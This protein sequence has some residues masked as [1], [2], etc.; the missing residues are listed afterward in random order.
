MS[1]LAEVVKEETTVEELLNPVASAEAAGLRYVSDEM[2]GIRRRKRGDSFS[3]VDPDGETVEHEKT[4]ARIESLVIPPAWTEVWI[5]PRANGHLQATGRD[6]KGRKQYRYHSKWREV[7]DAVKYD[8]MLDF[9][10]A[11]P[12][13]RRRVDRD[14]SLPGLPREKVLATVVRLLEQTRIRVG[15]E[16]YKAQN[17]SF[18]LTTLQDRH[19]DVNGSTVR[20]HF[21]GKSGKTHE[22]ELSD[23]R[24]ARIVGACKD[25]PGQDLFQYV[26]E[27]GVRHDVTSGD[28][29]DYIR[30]IAGEEF[31]AK[32]FRT[33]AGTVMAFGFLRECEPCGDE[34]EGKTV[35]LR[36]VETV[37][38]ELGNTVAVCRKC[39]VHPAVMTAYL[40][41]G[42]PE[43]KARRN[44]GSVYVLDRDEA[45]VIELLR[46]E[47]RTPAAA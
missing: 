42:L 32:D 12:K 30:E 20:F 41:G 31:S 3:Y 4:L 45:A 19:V 2:P 9:A 7:R 43:L 15:N 25:I 47:E 10:A 23:R 5:C 35:L 24:V 40:D 34:K 13:I 38:A 22:V 18:G 33:W 29:N 36:C 44:G 16:E 8:K 6:A 17:R 37:A 1:L 11:L 39:Y 27:D 26:D 46:A 28:V 14:L 21:K